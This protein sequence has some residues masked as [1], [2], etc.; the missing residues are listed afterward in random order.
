MPADSSMCQGLLANADKM[1]PP[2]EIASPKNPS[3]RRYSGNLV[4]MGPTSTVIMYS[5]P[6]CKVEAS[7]RMDAADSS[8][9]SLDVQYAWKMPIL[10]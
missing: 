8:G 4:K 1:M 5:S 3:M 2:T 6:V 10:E 7:V 9:N